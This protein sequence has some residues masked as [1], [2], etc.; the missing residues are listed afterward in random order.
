MFQKSIKCIFLFLISFLPILAF[1]M[2]YNVISDSLKNETLKSNIKT[3]YKKN[4][5]LLFQKYTTEHIKFLKTF[6]DSSA[7]AKTLDYRA[8]FNR[9]RNNIDS[10]YYYYHKSFKIYK[11]LKDSLNTGKTLLNIAIL[12]KNT[13]NYKGSQNSS[14]KALTYLLPTKNKRRISSIFNNLGIVYNN[15]GDYENALKYHEKSLEYRKQI[16]NNPIYLIQ[17][18]NNIGKIYKDQEQ[19][20]KAMDYFNEALSYTDAI[21]ISPKTKAALIDNLAHTIFKN[22]KRENTLSSF[23][24][25]LKIREQIEDHYGIIISCVH[26]SEYYDY[27]QQKSNAI[28][29]AQKAE[30]ISRKVKQNRDYLESLKLLGKLYTGEKSKQTYQKYI[31]VDDSLKLVAQNY[32]RSFERIKFEINE[33]DQLLKK[34]KQGNQIKYY[35]IICLIFIVL[36]IAIAYL[37]SKHKRKKQDLEFKE[38][39]AKLNES[40]RKFFHSENPT[41]DQKTKEAFTNW[42]KEKY[43][44]TDSLIEFWQLQVQGISEAQI[45]EQL[46]SVTKEAIRKRR[47]KLYKKLKEYYGHIDELDKFLS[48]SIYNKSF[49]DFKKRLKKHL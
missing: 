35:L 19:Y 23:L 47:N 4:D 28:L 40:Q 32:E 31:T 14:F 34:E 11:D 5:T 48:V 46:K 21:R 24:E 22:N 26:L 2:K 3:A 39:V 20:K 45:A 7:L 44:I 15:L 33:K 38:L 49:L 6:K 36:I 8:A 29:Y 27:S 42:L 10:T 12:Q 18:L 30:D 25:A 37:V 43:N 16:N 17:S 9:K 41:L 1:G 13:S